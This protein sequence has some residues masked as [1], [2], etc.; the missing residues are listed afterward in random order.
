VITV[1]ILAAVTAVIAAGFMFRSAQEAT[2]AG[3]TLFQAVALNLAEAGVE[4]GLFAAN[5]SG[6]TGANGW[7]LVA[8]SSTDYEKTI[9][10][11]FTFQQAT[12]SIYVRVDNAT[13]LTPTVIAAGKVSIPNR[14]AIVKQVRIGGVKRR[15]WTNGIVSRGTL[16]FSGSA[17][18]DSYDSSVGPY[19][20]A[21]NRTDQ[22]TVASASTAVDPVV[23]GSNASIY[24]YVA[25][26]G[27]APVVGAG[28][29]IYGATTPE[30][31]SV[32]SGRLRYDFTSNFPDVT[33][34][35]TFST[36]L[37]PRW[38][39]LQAASLSPG[40]A[41]CRRRAA[42]MS[43]ARPASPSRAAIP[44]R[45]RVPSTSS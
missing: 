33:A 36:G 20:S 15:L 22:V 40:S 32:D 43:T 24:G 16:T 38:A 28:G 31:T 34:P 19:N 4:E 11:G 17:V 6:F 27:A 14:P 41:M 2:L 26:T 3:R 21:T 45:S 23:V 9:T 37:L 35:T 7:A 44:C 10:S 13:S 8:G 1:L 5:T 12:G 18:I 25:T 30:G 29:R 42:G 39:M